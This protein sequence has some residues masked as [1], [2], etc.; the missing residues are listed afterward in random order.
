ME[1]WRRRLGHYY[2]ENINKY[3]SLHQIKALICIK[4]K[5]AKMTRKSH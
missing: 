3:K 5:V 1:I 4:Y 2:L